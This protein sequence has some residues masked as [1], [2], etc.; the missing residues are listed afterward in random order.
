M[1][2]RVSTGLVVD[3]GGVDELLMPRAAGKVWPT[4][5]VSGK[6]G[7]GVTK[8]KA[9]ALGARYTPRP[10]RTERR[11][12][13]YRARRLCVDQSF[14]AASARADSPH[15]ARRPLPRRFRTQPTRPRLLPPQLELDRR[16]IGH[17]GCYQ[18]LCCVLDPRT[19]FPT[20]P[21]QPGPRRG[22]LPTCALVGTSRRPAL[23]PTHFQHSVFF[24]GVLSPPDSLDEHGAARPGP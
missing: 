13:T 10:R 6:L 5:T 16:L 9:L 22:T 11:A 18:H 8:M 14:T 12:A 19:P 24:S 21:P 7:A 2:E 20:P 23:I 17:R 1:A 4:V 3:S 15:H